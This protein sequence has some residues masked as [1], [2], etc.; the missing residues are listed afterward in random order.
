MADET[1][2]WV[3]QRTGQPAAGLAVRNALSWNLLN[4]LCSQGV[5]VAVFLVLASRLEPAVFGAYALA[6]LLVD[7]VANEGRSAAVDVMV[8]RGQVS[9]RACAKALRVLLLGAACGYAALVAL[10]TALG[11]AA[12]AAN[13]TAISAV[14]GLAVFLAAPLAVYEARTLTQLRFR[15]MAARS[16]GGSIASAVITLAWL[17]A[18]PPEW[19]L[20]VQRLSALAFNLVT[21]AQLSPW[22]K[23]TDDLPPPS[24]GSGRAFFQIWLGQLLNFALARAPELLIGLRLGAADL[25]VFRVS[26]RLVDMMHGAATSPLSGVFVPVLARDAGDLQRLSMTYR[27]VTAISALLTAPVLVGVALL[28]E[29]IVE[30]FLKPDYGPGAQVI[31]LLALASLA[32]PFAHFRSGL[33]LSLNRPGRASALALLDLLL[34][35]AATYFGAGIDVA[36]AAAG[37][38]AASIVG[39]AVSL[40]VVADALQT[41]ATSLLRVVAPAFL[42]TAVM[43]LAVGVTQLLLPDGRLLGMIVEVVLGATSFSIYLLVA[44]R[45]WLLDLA[46]FLHGRP[47]RNDAI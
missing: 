31:A 39:A 30:L 12:H 25:G 5:S 32:A 37:V 13:L 10:S 22:P 19:A 16:M 44:H 40:L 20:V 4:H 6:S 24:S 46:A 43:A 14:L 1:E 33:L 27:K 2:P 47:S 36:Q 42:A 17:F 35:G 9:R 3:E 28:A 38:L 34:T 7:A 23:A 11:P 15:A 26:A 21:L 8:L 29:D 18:G 45:A 41:S